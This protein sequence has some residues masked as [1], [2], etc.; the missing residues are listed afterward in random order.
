MHQAWS[1]N[2]VCLCSGFVWFVLTKNNKQKGRGRAEHLAVHRQ[3]QR[4]EL[5]GG[6]RDPV[7]AGDEDARRHPQ[8][9][10]RDREG[11]PTT[12]ISSIFFNSYSSFKK[13]KTESKED[14]Q[15]Q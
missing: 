5:L 8:E 10:H 15:L 11:S 9:V 2:K 1:K 6:Q 7:R 3:L 13:T 4:D 14:E 12:I